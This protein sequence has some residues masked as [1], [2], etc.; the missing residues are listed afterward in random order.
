MEKKH[1]AKTVTMGDSS[2]KADTDYE[3]QLDHHFGISGESCGSENISMT[4]VRIKPG[5]R[6]R[7]HYH[8]NS[9]LAQYFIKGTGRYIVGYGTEDQEDFPF[10]P[11]TFIYIPRGVIHVIENTGDVDIE[12][13]AAYSCNSGEATGKMFC[14]MPLADAKE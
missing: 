8:I 13:I 3:K 10:G 11:G 4:F 7:A 9:E 5:H 14:E 12:S 1:W 2:L 6:A